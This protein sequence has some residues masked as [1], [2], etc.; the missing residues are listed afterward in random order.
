MDKLIYDSGFGILPK[1]V[2]IDPNLSL[3]AKGIFAYLVT[4]AGNGNEAFPS[5]RTISYQLGISKD[6]AGKYIKELK[7]NGYLEIEQKK[8]NG[9]FSHNVYKLIPCPKF[10][11][12]ESTS[13]DVTIPGNLASNIN[14][15]NINNNNINNNNINNNNKKE[16]E[17][18]LDKIIK[19]YTTNNDLVNTLVDFMKM[20][21]SI[22]KPLTDRALKG[23]L[24]KLDTLSYNDK[25]KIEILEQSIINCWSGVFPLKAK[26]N[27]SVNS[28]ITKDDNNNSDNIY[29]NV[30][31]TQFH[32]INQ[33][34][35]NYTPEELKQ[36]IK[37]SQK[38]KFNK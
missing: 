24:S 5:L 30:K 11:V 6:T 13:A 35:K 3:Q 25:E 16:K 34:Y 12:S 9:R 33:S 32:N 38:R 2:M 15:N 22:K 4:Y 26:N 37:E 27:N 8:E 19:E 18:T 1:R 29:G 7:E 14:N 20:R 17:T 28:I 21:K 10:T 31:K 23:I 36:I